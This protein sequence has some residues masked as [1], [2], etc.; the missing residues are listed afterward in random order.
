VEI[1]ASRTLITANVGDTSVLLL[2][3]PRPP[4]FLSQ[5]HGPDSPGEFERIERDFAHTPCRLRL[6]YTRYGRPQEEWPSIFAPDGTRRTLDM[7]VRAGLRDGLACDTAR[8]DLSSYAATPHMEEARRRDKTCISVTRALGNFYAHEFGLTCEPS[9]GVHQ[10]SAAGDAIVVA[11]SDGVW[12]A[13]A[14]DDLSAWLHSSERAGHSAQRLAD[15]L[16]EASVGRATSLFGPDGV[17]DTTAVV[18]R[19]GAGL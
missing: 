15:A 1:P 19:V 5:D 13:W 9:V 6:V 14:Y 17:D 12:D 2:P 4:E 3:H 16:V 8:N 7:L 11:A 18:W 10:Y